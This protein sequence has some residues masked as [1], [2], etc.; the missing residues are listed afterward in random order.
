MADLDG[1]QRRLQNVAEAL[2]AS[3]PAAPAPAVGVRV[4][5][6]PAPK[7]RWLFV[8]ERDSEGRIASLLA[9]PLA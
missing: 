7:H 4:V 9:E 8:I 3:E 5:E 1:L 6:M 2:K